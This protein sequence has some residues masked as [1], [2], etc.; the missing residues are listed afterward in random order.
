MK[1]TLHIEDTSDADEIEKAKAFLDS[2]NGEPT[3]P[4]EESNDKPRRSKKEEKEEEAEE[5]EDKEEEAEEEKE[6][7]KKKKS[8][9]DD[10]DELSAELRVVAK[11]LIAKDRKAMKK[12][13]E[14]FDTDSLSGIPPFKIAKAIAKIEAALED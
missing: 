5:P 13:L 12:I 1:I 14:S 3:E 7:K 6:D 2:L 8:G 11:K 10:H 4:S 9:D